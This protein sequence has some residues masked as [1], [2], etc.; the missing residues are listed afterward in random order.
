MIINITKPTVDLKVSIGIGISYSSNLAHAQEV[1]LA[2][3]IAHPNV[4]TD[5]S[6]I[7]HKLELLAKTLETIERI[8]ALERDDR[9]HCRLQSEVSNYKNAIKKHEVGKQLDDDIRGL[10]IALVRLK[11]EISELESG[12][13]TAAELTELQ[14]KHIRA[15]E[16]CVATVM[17]QMERWFLIPDPWVE[18]E[19]KASELDRWCEKNKRL[20][21][22]WHDLQKALV[23]PKQEQ[24]MR[25]DDMAQTFVDWVKKDY[26]IITESWKNPQVVFKGF[27][28][29]SI[30]LQLDFY[31]DDIRL[32]HFRR[33]QRVIA[34]IAREIHKRFQEEG[35]VIPFPQVDV[36]LSNMGNKPLQGGL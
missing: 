6:L 7:G 9:S 31:I 12:G 14:N 24:E 30:D 28:A 23:R 34:E 10:C 4:L 25:L 20:G 19:E 33:K 32:E 13:L 5:A 36:R 1:L 27:E 29:S 26:K 8:L 15:I 35:I 2:M 21:L 16:S 11:R 17:V 22:K 3:A 18:D